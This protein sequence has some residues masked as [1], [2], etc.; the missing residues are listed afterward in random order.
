MGLDGS[1]IAAVTIEKCIT[2]EAKVAGRRE[3][4]NYSVR[5]EIITIYEIRPPRHIIALL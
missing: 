4:R 1:K 5:R 2:P 3:R